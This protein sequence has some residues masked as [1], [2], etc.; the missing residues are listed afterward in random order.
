MTATVVLPKPKNVVPEFNDSFDAMSRST[1]NSTGA[2]KGG[3]VIPFK[4]LS[5]DTKGRLETRQLMVPEE[6]TMAVTVMKSEAASKLEKQKIKE[7]ILQI[8]LLSE[9]VSL[10]ID[11]R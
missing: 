8:E 4:L 6:T 1:Q 2:P 7:K 3:G 5:R 9:K 10:M 11:W